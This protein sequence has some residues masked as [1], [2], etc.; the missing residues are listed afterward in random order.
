[1][2]RA[3]P[4][5]ILTLLVAMGLSAPPAVAVESPDP[6]SQNAMPLVGADDTLYVNSAVTDD[7]GNCLSAA[8]SGDAAA[9]KT[10]AAAL[11]KAGDDSIIMVA[12][13]VYPENVIVSKRVN[14]MG[15][16][17]GDDPARDTVVTSATAGQATIT[18][19]TGGSD[20]VSRQVLSNVRVTGASGGSGNNN[21][22]ILLSG[23]SMGY[24][25]FD[26]VT[27]TGN[28]GNGLVSNVSPASSTLTD[29]AILNSSFSGN[30]AAG[31]R[32]AS[33]SVNGFSVAGSAIHDNGS[34]GIAF[35]PSDNTTA[36][37]GDVSLTNV[38]FSGQNAVA[39]LY[40][41]RMLGSMSLKN[42]DFLGS[43]G[44]GLFGLYLL[45]GY[46]NQDVAPAIDQ[47]TLE[48]VTVSGT[49]TSAGISFLG[50]SNLA[51]VSMTDVVLNTVVPTANRG[52]MRLSG[53]AGTLDVGNTAFNTSDDSPALDILLNPNFGSAGSSAT[54]AVDATDATFSGKTGAEMS[55]PERFQEQSRIVDRLVDSPGAGGLVTFVSDQVFALPTVGRGI[56]RAVDAA[57]SGDTIDVAPGSYAE[58]LT[59]VKSVALVGSVDAG[60]EAS[61]V[62]PMATGQTAITV[63]D[64]SVTL[65]NLQVKRLVS[66][67]SFAYGITFGKSVANLTMDNVT[68]DGAGVGLRVGSGTNV[69]GLTITKSHFDNNVQGWYLAAESAASTNGTNVKN[70]NVTNTTFNGNK[71]KGL[72]A[73]KLSSA[74]F[75]GITVNGSGMD[76]NYGFNNGIDINL[77]WQSY[78]DITIRNSSITNSGYY[79]TAPST[80]F[81]A[82]VTIKARDDTTGYCC[83]PDRPPAT[84]TGVTIENTIIHGPENALRLGEAGKVNRGPVNVTIVDSSLIGDDSSGNTGYSLINASEAATSTNG[85]WWGTAALPDIESARVSQNPGSV[86]VGSWITKFTRDP[87]KSGLPGFWALVQDAQSTTPAGSNVE[88]TFTGLPNGGQIVL[89]FA[90]VD[91]SGTTTVAPFIGDDSTPFPVTPSGFSLGSSPI[92]YTITTTATFTGPIELCFAYDPASFA[93]PPTVYH[94]TGGQWFARETTIRA[95]TPPQACASVSSFSQFALGVP[96]TPPTPDPTFPPSAPRD[97]A[98]TGGD[99]SISVTWAV[100]ADSG[101]FPV[102]SYQV[103]ALPGG[104]SCLVAAPALTCTITG[105][106]NGTTYTLRARALNGAGWSAWSAASTPVTPGTGVPGSPTNVTA[107]AGNAE[108][109]VTWT[110]PVDAGTSPIT[111]YRVEQSRANGAWTVAI[112]NTGSTE[113]LA[114]V[115]DLVNGDGYRFR[116][117]AIN[118]AGPGAVSQPSPT[119]TPEDP[120]QSSILIT[121]ARTTVKGKPG[122]RV[123]GETTGLDEGAILRPWLRFPGQSTFSRGGARILVGV[124]GG[125]TWQR[126]TGKKVTVYVQAGDGTR[127]NRVVIPAR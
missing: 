86:T 29:V 16:G 28:T 105:V 30:D 47:V 42:V 27:S 65:R 56:Q 36:E 97:V 15:A 88:D 120:E 5:V 37:I 54:V 10:I 87:S 91:T 118:A 104:S 123:T 73:E 121:G 40:A 109:V 89:Q 9:C 41:F 125:F 49:Y 19:T 32:T 71:Q 55:L 43:R 85:N 107:V 61:T 83:A 38:T 93:E 21:S 81:P 59:I 90:N 99:A 2:K 116:V 3:I 101:S 22:G 52:H 4:T 31:I 53:V 57:S 114:T 12:A 80:L 115:S 51:K 24:F 17:S 6:V 44:S 8:T 119:V 108:A 23:G 33:H 39:D 95:G 124:D 46:V 74:V 48:G 50:Y 98:G 64:D 7:T 35:N 20:S 113:E 1:M 82:A 110:A 18:Y 68:I 25:T 100:P 117:A 94:Y 60:G 75:D 14:I 102:T 84:L 11:S 13:G 126:K 70:V 106:T 127:S 111:G 76:P 77:K 63:S 58:P 67:D 103:E 112:A 26:N 96:V 72:Y 79:G 45:G 92:Y 69:D 34:N 122:I 66:D 62:L 78:A